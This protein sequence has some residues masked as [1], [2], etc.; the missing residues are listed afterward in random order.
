M[1][2][3]IYT[4]DTKG[5]VWLARTL[6]VDKS[7]GEMAII[8]PRG[9][10]KRQDNKYGELAMI[11]TGVPTSGM[12]LYFE[13]VNEHGV[14]VAALNFTQSANYVIRSHHCMPI[15]V[16]ELIPYLLSHSRTLS[17][18]KR[19]IRKI[20][21]SDAAPSGYA[22]AARLH[23]MAADAFGACVIEPLAGGITVQDCPI[24]VLTNEPPYQWHL[25]NAQFHSRISVGEDLHPFKNIGLSPPSFGCDAV[26]I[27]G[28]FSS[29]DRFIKASYVLFSS[30]EYI[31]GVTDIFRILDTVSVPRGSVINTDGAVGTVYSSALSL[32][33][34]S[35]FITTEASRRIAKGS[36]T[37]RN[38]SLICLPLPTSEDF[39]VLK[40]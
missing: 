37:D 18:L 21:I 16:H 19:I 14:G 36:I 12:P 11:G 22:R 5:G 3:A 33:D 10:L 38:G 13:A 35:Y 30:S 28:S 15:A 25:S 6:D 40:L 9:Y 1:C 4:T 8:A 24:P 29:A 32:T 27:S 17:E 2:T 39:S 34:A 20:G 26:G 31:H 7:Y 23:F